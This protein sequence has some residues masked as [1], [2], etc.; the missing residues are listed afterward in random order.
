MGGGVTNGVAY[1]LEYLG[2]VG[3]FFF[4]GALLFFLVRRRVPAVAILLFCATLAGTP[5]F[6]NLY[7]WLWLAM[8]L[9]YS[10]HPLA[11]DETT[12][13]APAITPV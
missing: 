12:A 7:W 3:T 13:S 4:L 1:L 10:R 2:A 6:T 8:L 5:L 9:I 11:N